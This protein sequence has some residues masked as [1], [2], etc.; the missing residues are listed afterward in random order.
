MR[1]GSQVALLVMNLLTQHL[2]RH[3]ERC[4]S[5]SYEFKM[6]DSGLTLLQNSFQHRNRFAIL[7]FRR[8]TLLIRFVPVKQRDSYL[9]FRSELYSGLTVLHISSARFAKIV[10]LE[11]YVMVTQA[12]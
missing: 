10:L 6:V 8:S 4:L 7:A 2:L 1:A 12:S 9:Y 11:Q 5:N 3:M